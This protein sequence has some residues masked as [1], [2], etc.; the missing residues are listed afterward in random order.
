MILEFHIN[1]NNFT[2]TGENLL[3]AWNK[4]KNKVFVL[5]SNKEGSQIREFYQLFCSSFGKRCNNIMSAFSTCLSN[6]SQP[7]RRLS[8]LYCKN[9]YVVIM[10]LG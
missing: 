6:T 8:V 4:E 2:K 9:L 7:N 10:S 5:K 3:N 1:E